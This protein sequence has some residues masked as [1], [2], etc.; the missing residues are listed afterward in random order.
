VSPT[1]EWILYLSYWFFGAITWAGFALALVNGRERMR[2]LRRPT[3]P[4]PQPPPSVSVLIPAKDEAAQIEKCV[5]SVLSQDYPNFDVIVIDDRS[6]DGTGEILDRMAANDSRL[7]VVHLQ[8]G[9]LPP[10]WGG[11]SFALHNGLMAAQGEWLLFVDADVLLTPPV[12]GAT[13]GVANYRGYDLVSL[14]PMFVS[15]T[16]WEGFL[17]PLAGAATSAMFF[18]PWTNSNKRTGSA[19]ANGQYLIV[20]RAAYE[21]VGGHEAIRGTL[22]EDVAIAR[23]MKAAGFKTRLGWGDTWATVRMYEGFGAIFRGWSRNFY[24]GSL[25]KPWRILGLIAFLLLC[26]LSVFAA[27]S[28]AMQTGST[29]WFVVSALHYA[30]MTATVG[31]MY[32]W[33]GEPKWYA[34][35][36]PLGVLF[37]LA[38]CVKSL[39]ICM[40]GRVTWRGTH[41]SAEALAGP[42]NV[43]GAKDS[44]QGAKNYART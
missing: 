43:E 40:T 9:S 2:I 14:L 41:Y 10:G 7:K 19:F 6:R 29:R 15:G 5:S 36:F 18:I 8:E 39:W 44:N 26:C 35:L 17:Q 30:I 21:S 38:V 1:G 20:K 33:A 16:F 3:P 23:K 42:S 34:L 11:K 13:I 12:M 32:H 22:S 24:V 25:G 4:I 27:A 37:L 31:L 28:W